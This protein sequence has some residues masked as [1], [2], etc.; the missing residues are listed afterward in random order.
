MIKAKS[1]ISGCFRAEDGGEIFAKLKSYTSTLRKHKLNIFN[2]IKSAFS[3][4]P[5]VF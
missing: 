1:K 2:G 5:V 3:L 4:N